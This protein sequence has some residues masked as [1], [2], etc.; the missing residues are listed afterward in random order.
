MI[1]RKKIEQPLLPLASMGDIAFLLIIFF[2]LT[3]TFMKDK[4]IDLQPPQS[5]DIDNLEPTNISV[6]VDK[7]GQV[8]LNG[9][10]TDAGTLQAAVEA[11]LGQQ[12]KKREVKV[13]VDKNLKKEQ[14]LP[15]LE[16][17]TG[18]GG[19]PILVGEMER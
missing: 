1:R 12:Q 2:M 5:P 19:T 7:E 16:A 15:V 14:F 9:I 3:A 11:L 6:T 10:E 18:G 17:V 8:Y 13:R 4:N